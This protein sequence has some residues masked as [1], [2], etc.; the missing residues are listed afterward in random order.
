MADGQATAMAGTRQ[1]LPPAN[2]RVH[3]EGNAERWTEW[4][5]RWMVYGKATRIGIEADDVQVSILLTV[6]GP[7]AHAVYRTF[8][9]DEEGDD[10]KLDKVLKAFDDFFEP[11]KNTAF[12]RY[13]FN[14]RGQETGESFEQ[15]VTALRQLA[16]RCAF[17]TITEDEILRDRVLF[18][19]K[20]QQVRERL[21]REANLS[22]SRTMDICRA[23]ES[24]AAQMKDI[25]KMADGTIHVIKKSTYMGGKAKDKIKVKTVATP[26]ATGQRVS[27]CKFCGKEHERLKERCPAWGKTCSRC[28]KPNHFAVKCRQAA[29]VDKTKINAMASHN[30]NGFHCSRW[31]AAV[32]R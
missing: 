15:Y 2:F 24:T 5:A 23:A 16:Q 8:A 11:R 9:W 13:R 4:K 30:I 10:Q 27:D 1:L 26:A 3:E 14:M 6:I 22:L 28:R 32:R 12:E 20:N 25:N 18:G 19:I 21:L 17:G 7:E 31:Q 29:G